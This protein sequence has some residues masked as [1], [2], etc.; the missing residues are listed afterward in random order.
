MLPIAQEFFKRNKKAKAAHV[1]LDR[2]FENLAAATAYKKFTGAHKVTSY[3]A[4]EYASYVA[5]KKDDNT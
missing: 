4:K 3:T 2:V 1:V 5:A